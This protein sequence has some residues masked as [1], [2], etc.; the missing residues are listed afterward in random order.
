MSTALRD[1]WLRLHAAGHR[2]RDA[3]ETLGVT[4]VELVASTCGS[5]SAPV[6]A[7]RLSTA[8]VAAL[9][10]Q[11]ATLG[12]VK[13]QTR[14]GCAVLEV[15]G[16]F[17]DACIRPRFE[18][19][20]SAFVVHDTSRNATRT[21]LQLFDAR[22]S[23]IHKVFLLRESDP[24]ALAKIEA[25]H[26]A[27]GEGA[28]TPRLVSSAD[29]TSSDATTDRAAR[30]E[31][32][33]AMGPDAAH[34]LSS[35][36]LSRLLRSLCEPGSPVTIAVH[37]AGAAH[38]HAVRA[39]RAVSKREWLSL[40]DTGVKLLIHRASITDMWSVRD[41]AGTA[42]SLEIFDGERRAAVLSY[43]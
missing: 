2:A 15:V 19:W 38:V 22:G 34:P 42:T 12:V 29:P 13:T 25:D 17:P 37:N 5:R 21:S 18:Q 31:Q 26:T 27:A 7:S 9:F 28:T 10:P 43:G 23:A 39:R 41:V 1:A 32:L 16:P 30:L 33:R 3:A 6:R 8:N 14:N 20:R 11:L 40:L 36:A 35:G 4:E 24:A